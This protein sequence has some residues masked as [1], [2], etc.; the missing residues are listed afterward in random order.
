[1]RAPRHETT[2]TLAAA[3]LA[4]SA[5]VPVAQAALIGG[6][7]IENF[8]SELT[9]GVAA[10]DTR[11]AVDSIN[12]SGMAGGVHNNTPGNM[13][14]V[15][16]TFTGGT[17]TPP[18]HITYDLEGNFDLNAIRIWNYN[19]GGLFNGQPLTIAGARDVEV[20]VS[21]TNNPADFVKLNN[22]GGDFVFTQAPGTNTYG[23]FNLNL[24]GVTN[25]AAL[26]NVRMVRFDILTSYGQVNSLVGL[27]EVQFSAVTP[28]GPIAVPNFSFQSPVQAAGTNSSGAAGSTTAI[29]NW[30]IQTG[31]GGVFFPNGNS[32]LGNPLPGTADGS[33]YAFAES[34]SN[35]QVTSL[36][37]TAGLGAIEDGKYTLTVAVGHR[38]TA[39]RL[40]D[41]YRIELLGDGNVLAFAE[42]L[43]ARNVIPAASF[44]DLTVTFDAAF[45]DL[46]KLLNI[47]LIHSTDD[48]VFRQGA[49]DNVRLSFEA[50]VP[51]P[52]TAALGLL[53]AAGLMMRRRRLA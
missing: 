9:A 19:E 50:H 5:S 4:L 30:T 11:L 21:P 34:S 29:T 32:G 10:A 31:A 36:L 20:R 42:L 16:G 45:A 41:N 12:Q 1:M 33:Q 2:A 43:D 35:A 47:R 40:P 8:S 7:T 13:W 27:A 15:Q 26:D 23:G 22:A 44:V 52:T 48:G 24:S 17:D 39:A 28:N 51:E 14:E 25:K 46:G 3:L 6:V 18:W 38:N 37:L 49:F 53:G